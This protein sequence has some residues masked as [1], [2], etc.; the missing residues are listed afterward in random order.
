MTR[1]KIVPLRNTEKSCTETFTGE[2]RLS[3]LNQVFKFDND[4]FN[5][6]FVWSTLDSTS[7]I[8]SKLDEIFVE[9]A[10]FTGLERNL[11]F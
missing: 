7:R 6:D 4:N 5:F 11:D 3:T 9:F 2:L 8:E 1:V 10:G